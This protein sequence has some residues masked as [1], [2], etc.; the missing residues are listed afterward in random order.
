MF[1]FKTIKILKLFKFKLC[2]YFEKILEN[3]FF[4][5]ILVFEKEKY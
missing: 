2:S 1:D 3:D 4:W 5:K